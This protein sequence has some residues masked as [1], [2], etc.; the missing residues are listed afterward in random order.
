[1]ANRCNPDNKLAGTSNPINNAISPADYTNTATGDNILEGVT[2]GSAVS[3]GDIVYVD[4]GGT[5][6]QANASSVSTSRVVGVCVAKS[7]STVCNV[8]TTGATSAILSGLT[9]NNNYFLDTTSGQLTLT[10]PSA[11]NNVVIH[12]G[13][14]LDANR[15]FIQIGIQFV[16][17]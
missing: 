17:S 16:R 12:I 11:T 2:C 13:R 5:F 3:V 8:Q 9:A 7:S 15:I 10:P 6:Q 1:M 4:G 14:A